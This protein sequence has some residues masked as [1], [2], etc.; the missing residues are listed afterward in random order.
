ML[1]AAVVWHVTRTGSPAPKHTAHV[2]VERTL[3]DPQGKSHSNARGSDGG[4]R[5]LSVLLAF[6]G[7]GTGKR[8]RRNL[9]SSAVN[10]RLLLTLSVLVVVPLLTF[11]EQA[12][13]ARKWRWHE[14]MHKWKRKT[15]RA[16]QPKIC[17]LTY[18][19]AWVQA[20]GAAIFSLK[21][22]TTKKGTE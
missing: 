8:V 18:T 3:T 9:H 12:S 4:W 15:R 19:D 13:K 21:V 11:Q 10:R 2:P 17:S 22:N 20:Q 14:S 7:S 16:L 6:Q 1:K 5:S